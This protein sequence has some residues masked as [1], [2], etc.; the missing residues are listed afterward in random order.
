MISSTGAI[1]IGFTCT[2]S[3]ALDATADATADVTADDS[4]LGIIG[5]EL[6]AIAAAIAADSSFILS[7]LPP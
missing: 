5:S 1:D 7:F 2:G 4:D 3:V 6:C